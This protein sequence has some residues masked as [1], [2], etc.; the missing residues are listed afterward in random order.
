MSTFLPPRR[1]VDPEL[2]GKVARLHY[3]FGLTHQEIG[4]ILRLSRVKVTR[5]LQQARDVGI[6]SIEVRTDASPYAALEVELTSDVRA[7]TRR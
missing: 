3:D 1:G 6:V 4:E 2:L 7:S 5:L